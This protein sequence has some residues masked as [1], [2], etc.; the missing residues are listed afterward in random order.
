MAVGL[1]WDAVLKAS[2]FAYYLPE[3]AEWSVTVPDAPETWRI[4]ATH[5]EFED[6]RRHLHALAQTWR[7]NAEAQSGYTLDRK[8]YAKNFGPS[9]AVVG[10]PHGVAWIVQPGL[11]PRILSFVRGKRVEAAPPLR[12]YAEMVYAWRDGRLI[13]STVPDAVLAC[14]DAPSHT[15][16]EAAGVRLKWAGLR[17]GEMRV[18]LNANP[19]LDGWVEMPSAT[20]QADT[21]LTMRN[22]MDAPIVI[23]SAYPEHLDALIDFTE[24]W[25]ATWPHAELIMTFNDLLSRAWRFDQLQDDWKAVA[26]DWILILTDTGPTWSPALAVRMAGEDRPDLF[27]EIFNV[28]DRRVLPHAW[29]GTRGRLLPLVGPSVTLTSAPYRDGWIYALTEPAMAFMWTQPEEPV[30]RDKSLYA[31]FDLQR[32]SGAL[33][34]SLLKAAEWELIPRQNGTDVQQNWIPVLQAFG[35]LNILEIH[36][37][38]REGRL[39][40]RGEFQNV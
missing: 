39:A 16:P 13:C 34:D 1:V 11:R 14:L 19:V 6:A 36:G 22:A 2:A 8:S 28:S 17:A 37:E 38:Q 35:E 33:V 26:Q 32:I 5:P 25:V 29:Y 20:P 12:R 31:R 9:I 21:P 23:A 30:I 4:L 7:N 10:T 18:A 15:I 40:F 3:S 27:S 24:E